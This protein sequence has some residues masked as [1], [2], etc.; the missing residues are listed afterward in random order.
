M[1]KTCSIHQQYLF[2]NNIFKNTSLQEEGGLTRVRDALGVNPN[3]VCF[4]PSHTHTHT[5]WCKPNHEVQIAHKQKADEAT[6]R[7]QLPLQAVRCHK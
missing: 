7:A 4:T 5:Q 1:Q 3:H 6:G 2:I